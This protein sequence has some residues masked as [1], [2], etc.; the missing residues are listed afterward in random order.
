MFGIKNPLAP[1][2]ERLFTVVDIGTEYVK[3]LVC[4]EQGKEVHILGRGMKR[5]NPG[6]MESGTITDI[7]GVIEHCHAAMRE[8]ERMAGVSPGQL[9]LG[10][11][12]E[13]I[14]GATSTISYKRR[15]PGSK[16][17]QEELKNIVHKVQWKAFEKVRSDLAFETGFNEIDVK[18]VH[19]AIVDTRIDGY[20]VSNPIGFQG[21]EVTM[22]VFNAFSPVVHFG[23]LQTISAELDKE[24]LAI[25]AEPYAVG[26]LLGGT[27]LQGYSGIF[28]D[29]GG[30]TTDIT[31]V[32][33]GSVVATKMFNL[34]GRA[35]TKRLAQSLNISHEEAEEVKIAFSTGQL[36][37]Q[38]QSIVAK[39]L[40]SDT[41][42][43]LSGVYFSLQ[44]VATID[45]LPPTVY[46]CGGGS[47]LPLLKDGLEGSEWHKKLNF[48][49][50]PQIKYL[51]P[52]N[53]SHVKDETKLLESPQDIPPMALASIGM[54]IL[55][56]EK[57]LT[58]MLQK[59]VRLMQV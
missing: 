26:R 55:T 18:L 31:I 36:E 8:A 41:D 1:K 17:H 39:A 32:Q 40:Q 23:A 50:K 38:S 19:A 43:W 47:L 35:F 9:V 52:K 34:G 16:I 29:M 15:D 2:R 49:R 58:K 37:H 7:A 27:E 53:I 44:E 6:E 54:E 46:L 21:R 4:L 42:I 51:L 20:K 24:L 3:A 45:S 10:V 11:A 56:E 48:P 14:K 12:G 13:L 25:M 30:S 28:L 59:V 33:D 22:S 57:I 5:Q